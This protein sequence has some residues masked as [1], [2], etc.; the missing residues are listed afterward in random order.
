MG[1]SKE[2]GVSAAPKDKTRSVLSLSP[3]AAT[4]RGISPG[5]QNHRFAAHQVAL[6]Y[7]C[8]NQVKGEVRPLKPRIEGMFDELKAATEATPSGSLSCMHAE[9]LRAFTAE[10]LALLDS[11]PEQICA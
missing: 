5:P 11:M 3:P 7:Q 8:I 9:W 1:V 4:A 2:L 10:L 6:L